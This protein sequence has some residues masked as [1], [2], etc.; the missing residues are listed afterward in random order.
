MP[1]SA[2][3]T[4]GG[5][6]GAAVHWEIKKLDSDKTKDKNTENTFANVHKKHKQKN[7]KNKF[8]N[9][10]EKYNNWKIEI[11]KNENTYT[12]NNC[13]N[14]EIWKNTQNTDLSK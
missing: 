2:H 12:C 4:G 14:Y 10:T 3:M 8:T 5:G 11:K 6:V 9:N 1:Q 7:N 13:K